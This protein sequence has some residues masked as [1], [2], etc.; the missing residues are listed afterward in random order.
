M[1]T[2]EALS[3]S[4]SYLSP[5]RLQIRS[6]E[7]LIVDLPIKRP[8][9]FSATRI[10]TQAYLI[11]KVLT[12]DGLI[13]VGEGATPGGPWWSG[14]SIET[15]KEMIDT[16][17]APALIGESAVRITHLHNRMNRVA[18][19]NSFAKAAIDMALWDVL[20]KS[21]KVPTHAL[22][23][24]Q[25]R[26]KSEIS[27]ALA[28]NKA[29]TDIA[30]A[31][32]MLDR[33][34]ARVF[35]LKGGALPPE[36]DVHRAV[37]V[38]KA[39]DGKAEIRIDLNQ[40]WDEATARRWLPT[41]L[42]SGVTL[43]EQPVQGWNIDALARLRTMFNVRIMA[44][45][46][47][48]TLQSALQITSLAAADVLALKLM[49]SG[50]LTACRQISGIAEAAGIATYGGTFLEGSLGT[51][52]GLQL[53]AAE[54]SLSYGSEYIGGIWLADEIVTH[55]LVYKDFHVEVPSGPGL[56]MTLDEDKISHFRRKS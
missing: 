17:L 31:E 15:M 25:V 55:P 3:I 33:R 32:S 35:K 50:G 10:T 9:Q 1:P 21:L 20:G 56:G 38:A 45:E 11:V 13:G 49:K 27:W 19:G 44:D 48:T 26:D 24:G 37:A 29:D 7:T 47:L 6:I 36:E 43:I 5:S 46:S 34:L 51:S 18:F 2:Q 53:V 52:A 42:D 12:E 30:E 22:F 39:M 8:H 14:D 41:L 23:G 40:A 4:E 54:R 16:Y 28:T